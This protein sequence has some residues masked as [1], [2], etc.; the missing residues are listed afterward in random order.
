MSQEGSLV[1][2]CPEHAV[3]H[4]HWIKETLAVDQILWHLDFGAMPLYNARH[5]IELFI[6]R[7]MPFI[8]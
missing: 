6:D 3:D 8:T 2:F 1:F 7:V 4:I 5:T